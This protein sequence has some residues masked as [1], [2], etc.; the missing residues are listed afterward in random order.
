MVLLPLAV[1]VLFRIYTRFRYR[2]LIVLAMLGVILGLALCLMACRAEML[3]IFYPSLSVLLC[4]GLLQYRK[5]FIN[6]V[7]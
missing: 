3:D 4:W 6:L 7:V 5:V 2:C 1:A